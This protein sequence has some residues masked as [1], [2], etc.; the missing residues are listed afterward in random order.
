MLNQFIY[1][2]IPFKINY[3]KK[4]FYAF[5]LTLLAFACNP[6]Q[7][8]DSNSEEKGAVSTTKEKAAKTDTDTPEPQEDKAP[9]SARPTMAALQLDT[10][11]DGNFKWSKECLDRLES[12]VIKEHSDWVRREAETLHLIIENGEDLSFTTNP[13]QSPSDAVRYHLTNYYPKIDAYRV[14]VGY[15]EGGTNKLINRKSG[16]TVE[17]DG[18]ILVSPD[19]NRFVAYNMDMH[20]TYFFNGFK[21]FKVTDNTYKLEHKERLR[22]GPDNPRWLSNNKIEFDKISEPGKEPVEKVVYNLTNGEWAAQ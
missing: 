5:V 17:V 6:K 12:Y 2:Y 11:C 22:W 16:N 13:S 20:T 15:Y 21:M 4:I 10:I 7:S 14:N 8:G 1:T 19:K 9:S 3:M 18:E